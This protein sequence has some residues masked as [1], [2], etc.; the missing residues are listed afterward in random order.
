MTTNIQ[1]RVSYHAVYDDSILEALQFAKTNGFAGIQIADETPHLSFERL[2]AAEVGRIADFIR[3][4]GVYATLHAPD[5]SASL[6]QCSRHLAAGVSNYYRALFSF[7]REIDA[8]LVTVHLGAMTVFPTDDETGRRLPQ[9]DLPLYSSSLKRNL[10]TLLRLADGRTM[11]CVENYGLGEA[12]FR[13]LEPYLGR[14][15]LFLC[16]DLV[17]GAGQPDI[18]ARYLEHP[19]W[20]KQVHLHDRRRTASG[21]LKGHRGIGTGDIDFTRALRLLMRTATVDDFC[22]EVRPREKARESLLALERIVEI[23]GA[24]QE[25]EPYR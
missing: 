25:A 8:R 18:E 6:F 17:K 13:L 5:E 20:I 16:W 19:E 15:G 21:A 3:A 11:V 23:I 1:N 7:A 9:K 12:E 22:I 24:E 4:E 14:D 10:E 2:S